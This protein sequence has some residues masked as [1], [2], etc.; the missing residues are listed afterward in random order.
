MA[1]YVQRAAVSYVRNNARLSSHA[2]T[3]GGHGGKFIYW[4]NYVTFNL[5]FPYLIEYNLFVKVAGNSGRICP[6]LLASLLL[7]WEC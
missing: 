3:A 5:G 4:K 1:S 6:Y 7:A 2:A